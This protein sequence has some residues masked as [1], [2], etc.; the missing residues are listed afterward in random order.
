MYVS[1]D[2]DTDL[3]L[4]RISQ[5]ELLCQ[6]AEEA[7]ELAHAALK[8]KRATDG[9]NPTPVS[10]EK[11]VSNLIEEIA[12]VG[13]TVDICKELWHIQDKDIEKIKTW[14]KIRWAERLNKVNKT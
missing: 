9:N 5:S 10:V 1:D 8:L 13:L 2:V 3:I 12:D 6:L 7:A 4:D 14:K 11:A